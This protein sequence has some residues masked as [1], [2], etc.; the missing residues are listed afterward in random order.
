MEEHEEEANEKE[1]ED[2]KGKEVEEEK[3]EVV[4]NRR[5]RWGIRKK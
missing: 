4:W 5:R 3:G 1:E 2:V